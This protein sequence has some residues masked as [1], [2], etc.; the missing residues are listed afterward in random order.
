MYMLYF[1]LIW[2][3]VIVAIQ[4]YCPGGL[5]LKYCAIYQV[6]TT[7]DNSR[8]LHDSSQSICVYI[9]IYIIHDVL[10]CTVSMYSTPSNTG[11]E[12]TN[13]LLS[14]GEL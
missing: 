6:S 12:P 7:T 5:V 14:S 10:S 4:V 9:Y 2:D 8:L 13:A 3:W 1:D 11:L